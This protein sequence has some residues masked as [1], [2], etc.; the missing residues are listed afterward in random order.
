M[1]N[2]K[3]VFSLH[4]ILAP[5]TAT[6]TGVVAENVKGS[7]CLQPPI[8]KR[9]D[10]SKISHVQFPPLNLSCL[11]TLVHIL[12]TLLHNHIRVDFFSGWVTTR[13]DDIG[14]PRCKPE[15]GF[16]SDSI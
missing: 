10:A 7:A 16:A 5:W 15:G 14:S 11:A 6:Q 12:L 4:D 8:R 9:L 2:L 3:S 13:Q 1:H